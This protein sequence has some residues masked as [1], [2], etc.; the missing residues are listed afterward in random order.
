MKKRKSRNKK[1]KYDG[2]DNK[3]PTPAIY[4]PKKDDANDAEE[5]LAEINR[6]RQERQEWNCILL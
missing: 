4:E 1:I 6:Q 2:K 5:A 3:P